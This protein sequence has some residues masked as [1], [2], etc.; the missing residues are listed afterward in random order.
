LQRTTPKS[1]GGL[2]SSLVMKPSKN[3]TKYGKEIVYDGYDKN[4]RPYQV[5]ANSLNRGIVERVGK[6]TKRLR[7]K[8]IKSRQSGTGA[9]LFID[10]AQK[11]LTGLTERIKDNVISNINNKLKNR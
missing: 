11:Q 10:N 3:A 9:L 5:I 7:G 6:G 2:V 8:R 1:T 4:G